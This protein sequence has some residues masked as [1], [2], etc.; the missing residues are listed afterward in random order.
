MNGLE[1]K[2]NSRQYQKS[3]Y[4]KTH[5]IAEDMRDL[6]NEYKTKRRP[7]TYTVGNVYDE[8]II[9]AFSI[10]LQEENVPQSEINALAE[11]HGIKS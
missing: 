1:E 3:L 10:V 8:C 4:I 7:E 9:A 5:P 2:T 6:M 11:K